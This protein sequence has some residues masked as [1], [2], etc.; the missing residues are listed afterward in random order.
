MGAKVVQAAGFSGVAEI[1]E[2]LVSAAVEGGGGGPR[3]VDVEGDAGAD[4]ADAGV[5]VEGGESADIE[6][7]TGGESSHFEGEKDI[8]GGV[9][10]GGGGVG[11][12]AAILD[13]DGA[14]TSDVDGAG[15]AGEGIAGVS[16][17]DGVVGGVAGVDSG[18][19]AG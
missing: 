19:D 9:V 13:V 4:A 3:V 6:D 12:V 15:D 17:V 1:K 16:D 8:S 2:V 5:D 7:G 10:D 14:E 11:G 18:E